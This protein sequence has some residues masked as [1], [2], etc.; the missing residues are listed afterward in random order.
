LL[1]LL[2][3]SVLIVCVSDLVIW[4]SHPLTL[5]VTPLQ[6][7]IDGIAQLNN[8]NSKLKAAEL[9]APP[10]PPNF[11]EEIKGTLAH[12][13]LPPLNIQNITFQKIV[14]TNVSAL[15]LKNG[16]SVEQVHEDTP[17]LVVVKNGQV[18]CAG[19]CSD[20]LDAEC[21]VIDLW[22]GSI[23]PALVATNAQLGLQEIRSESSTNDG[24][25]IDPLSVTEVPDI[26]RGSVPRA[27]DGLQF[28][29]RDA[30]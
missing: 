9:Q 6:V 26:I 11:N 19:H 24:R 10:T 15:W 16:Y 5:G 21:V 20:S 14:F 29:A 27:M 4:D 18:E 2:F 7:Y 3:Y 17:L 28:G 13:G 30:L 23:F 12:D 25:I 22:G 8:P 1:C